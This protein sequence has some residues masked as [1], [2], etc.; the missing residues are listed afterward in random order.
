MELINILTYISGFC[1]LFVLCRVFIVPLKAMLKLLLNS[2]FGAIIILIINFVGS[3]FSFHV[4]L[5]FFTIIF[6]SILGIPGAVLLT[7]IKLM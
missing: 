7:L 2:S 6:V 4:G 1:I 5:N 3:F